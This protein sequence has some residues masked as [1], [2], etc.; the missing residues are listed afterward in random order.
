MIDLYASRR[1][2]LR[3]LYE[4]EEQRHDDDVRSDVRYCRRC[5]RVTGQTSYD[6]A[7]RCS[8]AMDEYES[9]LVKRDLEEIRWLLVDAT[10]AFRAPPRD[11]TDV[12]GHEG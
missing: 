5:G 7:W 12:K 10:R 9:E 2:A 3:R 4:L 6:D 8:T 11:C 1:A